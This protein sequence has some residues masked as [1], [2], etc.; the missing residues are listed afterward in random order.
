VFFQWLVIYQTYVSY[1]RRYKRELATVLSS[2]LFGLLHSYSFYYVLA[3][4]F[5]GAV[6]PTSFCYFRE[7]TNWGSAIVYVK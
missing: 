7:K 3:A 6:L 1:T 2:L 5:A 4:T